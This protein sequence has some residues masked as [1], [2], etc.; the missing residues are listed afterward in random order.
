ME[1]AQTV[2]TTRAN[3]Y[4]NTHDDSNMDN[5]DLDENDDEWTLPSENIS[6]DEI[7]DS[8][9]VL[10]LASNIG[11]RSLGVGKDLLTKKS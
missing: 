4:D 8:M 1:Y 2:V 10:S 11:K 5:Q 9:G 6:D 7:N 3:D